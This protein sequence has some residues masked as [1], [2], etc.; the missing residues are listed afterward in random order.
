[1]TDDEKHN[2][3]NSLQNAYSLSSLYG[4]IGTETIRME[5][6]A[7]EQ[8]TESGSFDLRRFQLTSMGRLLDALPVMALL[9]GSDHRIIFAN[10]LSSKLVG[11]HEQV[12][13]SLYTSLFPRPRDASK[14]YDILKTV[15][16]ERKLRVGEGA[17]EL[18]ATRL[19]GRTNLRPIRLGSKRF[20]LVLI[21]DLSLEKKHLLLI[22]RHKELISQAKDAFE[23]ELR[24]R[25]NELRESS[26]RLEKEVAERVHAQQSLEFNKE[27]FR[28][29]VE[30]TLEGILILDLSETVV[31]ANPAA[32]R[33][34]G[35]TIESMLGERL[36]IPSSPGQIGAID[37]MRHNGEDGVAEARVE[38]T[39]WNGKPALLVL[40]H[41]ITDIRRSERQVLR[42]QKL[43][44][45]ELIA[46]G[47]AHDFN[48]LLTANVANL[49]LAK[50][51][52]TPGTPIYEAMTKA[53]KAAYKARDLTRQLLTFTKGKMPVKRPTSLLPLLRESVL[54]SLCGSNV[55]CD[56]HLPEDLWPVEAEPS[57]LSMLFQ[58]LIINACQAMPEGGSITVQ[59]ENISMN[60]P[61]FENQHCSALGRYIRISLED[62]GKGIEPQDLSR[63]F[64]PYFSTKP[65][66]SGLGLATAHSVVQSHGGRIEVKSKVGIGTCFY[67]YLPAS[68]QSH[69]GVEHFF[70]TVPISGTGR[71]LVVDDEEDIREAA[72]SLLKLLGYEVESAADGAV[73]I[74]EYRS[75]LESGNSFDAVIID[76]IVPGG[77]GGKATAEKLLEID[78]CVSIILSTGR[79][80]DPVAT[81]YRQHGFKGLVTKPY[82][83]AELGAALHKVLVGESKREDEEAA[84]QDPD[85]S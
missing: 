68:D 74:E 84:K 44:S 63:I 65:K 47:I 29:I 14:A 11:E 60:Y 9:V 45:L 55:K 39:E 17:I 69:E 54:L 53:E 40:I 58:N 42:A 10:N 31:Y 46:G 49:S 18:G 75:A 72:A 16:H 21:E 66:G 2:Q 25:T 73:A 6:Q 19:W 28:S 34:F 76:L 36:T 4:D 78:P 70:E 71:I 1:M 81:N 7:F 13:G 82:T 22:E 77:M 64:D 32:A 83:A 67:V 52:A 51:R 30:K 33:M 35:R 15:F 38:R 5:G 43:E 48:N 27:G 12:L 59:A 50:M 61:T 80:S 8:L 23:K 26:E 85:W 3:Y 37:V 41:D 24:E 57:Q 62:T 79:L 20:V 56:L